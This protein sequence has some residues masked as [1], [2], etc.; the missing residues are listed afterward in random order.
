MTTQHTPGPWRTDGFVTKD[1]D[2]ISPAGRIAMID[3]DTPDADTLEANAR[4]ISAAPDL[5]ALLREAH[6]AIATGDG[7]FSPSGDWFRE[8]AAAISKATGN[9]Q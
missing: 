2:I 6:D 9:A 5:L 7:D 1:L 3:C 4:L 8:T